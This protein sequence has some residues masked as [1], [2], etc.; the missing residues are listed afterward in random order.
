MPAKHFKLNYTG[1]TRTKKT[2]HP[3]KEC[4]LN[5]VIGLLDTQPLESITVDVVLRESGVSKGSLYHHFE[6]FP[7]LLEHALVQ[8]FSLGVDKSIE[9]LSRVVRSSQTRDEAFEGLYKVTRQSTNAALADG[10]FERTKLVGFSRDNPRLSKKLGAE[11]WRLTSALETLFRELQAKGWM[12]TDFDPRAAAVLIQAYSLGKIVDD[13]VDE[14]VDEE[15]WC[16]LID[17]V[18]DRVF[19]A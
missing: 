10:R 11:Q 2:I 14:K 15:A 9:K 6:D 5:T 3:T 7:D 13:M 1:T 12:S 18:T 19:G 8:R 17:K 4:L 16:K